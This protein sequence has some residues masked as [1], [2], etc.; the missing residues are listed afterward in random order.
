[1]N[2]TVS[3]QRFRI[4]DQE[5]PHPNNDDTCISYDGKVFQ[6]RW[7]PLLAM[8]HTIDAAIEKK[9]PFK[10]KNEDTGEI[11]HTRFHE[12]RH[13]W[14]CEYNGTEHLV[15]IYT[16]DHNAK[17]PDSAYKLVVYWKD[18]SHQLVR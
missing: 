16:F 9:L 3:L 13:N 14:Y 12:D 5:H 7:Y 4:S 11:G 2:T 17:K 15:E 1:M 18:T 8:G 10:I 6:L